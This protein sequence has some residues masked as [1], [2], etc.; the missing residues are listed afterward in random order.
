MPSLFKKKQSE[1]PPNTSTR[2]SSSNPRRSPSTV[3]PKH[4]SRKSSSTNLSSSTR[5]SPPDSRSKD[6][7]HRNLVHELYKLIEK[8]EKEKKNAKAKEEEKE[9]KRGKE[10]EKEKGKKTKS[11]GFR[12]NLGGTGEKMGKA[13]TTKSSNIPLEWQEEDEEFLWRDSHALK[14]NYVEVIAQEALKNSN[15]GTWAL[16]VRRNS[17]GKD[18]RFTFYRINPSEILSAVYHPTWQPPR[19]ETTE[20]LELKPP[21]LNRYMRAALTKAF[22][23]QLKALSADQSVLY[24]SDC[25]G[26]SFMFKKY[27]DDMKKHGFELG[28]TMIADNRGEVNVSS[29]LDRLMSMKPLILDCMIAIP[30][31]FFLA[32]RN[33]VGNIAFNIFWEHARFD[34]F[35]LQYPSHSFPGLKFRDFDKLKS[36]KVGQM[37]YIEGPPSAFS[38]KPDSGCNGFNVLCVEAGENPVFRAFQ[39]FE[40]KT[41]TEKEF[42]SFME[43]KFQKP[44]K[45][46][47]LLALHSKVKETPD[48][49]HRQ[50]GISYKEA[51]TML[52]KENGHDNLRK[53]L[54]K[55]ENIHAELEKLYK[56]K[57]LD[58]S[59][60]KELDNSCEPEINIPKHY[61]LYDGSG[62]VLIDRCYAVV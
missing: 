36:I 24:L 19:T 51:W 10:K 40:E 30:L 57:K 41:M 43:S 58:N 8:L 48:E 61:R 22:I 12:H 45:Y 62:L 44:L 16:N 15:Q 59:K 42:K 23:A 2:R 53:A 3:D 25:D 55:A 27:Q 33:V 11:T 39:S 5:E 1:S 21:T 14:L 35:I 56:N 47:G 13:T 37:V 17:V 6:R 29:V 34:A 9:K 46:S 49:V 31:S 7:E 18:Y 50:S 4:V 20:N 60:S 26:G 54:G 32:Y 38:F 52:E 28:N